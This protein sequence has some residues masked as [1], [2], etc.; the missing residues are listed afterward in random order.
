MKKTASPITLEITLE[1]GW[2]FRV[3]IEQ[4]KDHLTAETSVLRNGR[5]ATKR[6]AELWRD[7]ALM[8]PAIL[9]KDLA[10]AAGEEKIATKL[11]EWLDQYKKAAYPCRSS[12]PS[13][14]RKEAISFLIAWRRETLAAQE[15]GQKIP[16]G[17]QIKLL[18][19]LLTALGKL[20]AE[21]F[22]GLTEG[23]QI[24][25]KRIYKSKDGSGEY[26]DRWLLEYELRLPPSSRG[27]HTPE[28]IQK[29]V[30][31][32]SPI[33]VKELHEKLHKLPIRHK[34]KPRGKASPNYGF[35]KAWAELKAG[36]NRE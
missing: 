17:D 29:L 18:S 7:I 23:V 33:T 14:E 22:K 13:P 16:D 21:F 27:E 25:S 8:M 9:V 10:R 15:S 20:D 26:L 31:K 2:Q 35:A 4:H 12:E 28:E 1:G 5:P 34:D 30:S 32:F 3:R 19:L 24:L 6:E 11:A 36:L